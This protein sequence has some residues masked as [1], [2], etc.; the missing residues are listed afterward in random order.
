MN[1][2]RLYLCASVYD[3]E[4]E[5]A[6]SEYLLAVDN[7]IPREGE[8]D[9]DINTSFNQA[10]LYQL[11]S[12]AKAFSEKEDFFEKF[13]KRIYFLEVR[14]VETADDLPSDLPENKAYLR[15]LECY[16]RC[17]LIL[18]CKE[19]PIDEILLPK[20]LL[21]ELENK[22]FFKQDT[23]IGTLRAPRQIG[24]CL[25][26]KFYHIPAKYVE[27]YEL[28]K[29]VAIYQSE[30]MFGEE[31]SGI[32][33]YGEVR[34]SARLQRNRIREIPK[35]SKE[36]YYKFKVRKWQRLFNTISAKEIGFVRLFTSMSLLLNANEVPELTL[37]NREDFILYRSI[38]LACKP[39]E[40]KPES[41]FSGFR[42]SDFDIFVGGRF[43]YLCK[44]NAVVESY[45]KKEFSG[46]PS[47]FLK[48]IKEGMKKYTNKL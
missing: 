15:A 41:A 3:A 23:L 45:L 12:V 18:S 6:L 44:G 4:A 33:Y 46:A 2:S 21:D 39:L 48:K 36:L 26:R 8:L 27:D 1:E 31:L 5:R 11:K 25:N 16:E 10:V 42:H 19:A 40:E 17:L 24:V 32:K 22:D 38:S 14:G 7:L 30:R 13:R 43:I 29:Y 35:D 28:P 34:K 37:T 20:E 47:A 9:G